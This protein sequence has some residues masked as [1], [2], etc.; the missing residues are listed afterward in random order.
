MPCKYSFDDKI[1]ES[2]DKLLEDLAK[3]KGLS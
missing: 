2:Y 1:Y 3:H